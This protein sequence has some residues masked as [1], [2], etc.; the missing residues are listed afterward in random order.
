MNVIRIG[1]YCELG[2]ICIFLMSFLLY[3]L[4]CWCTHPLISI[5]MNHIGFEWDA[6]HSFSYLGEPKRWNNNYIAHGYFGPI[7]FTF[8]KAGNA[9]NIILWLRWRQRIAK[10]LNECECVCVWFRTMLYCSQGMFLKWAIV[11]VW[12]YVVLASMLCYQKLNEE[13]NCRYNIIY[14]VHWIFWCIF[15]VF[16][17]TIL[18]PYK[19]IE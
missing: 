7:N 10:H 14:W 19:S 2:G 17:V 8:Q 16:L 11:A 15:I 12:I 5:P 1:M 18:A 3:F 4:R 9:T 6:R 13:I